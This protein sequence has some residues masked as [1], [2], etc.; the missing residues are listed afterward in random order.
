M[1]F[2]AGRS[3]VWIADPG[4]C[5]FSGQTIEALV[6]AAMHS[7]TGVRMSTQHRTDVSVVSCWWHMGSAGLHAAV[8]YPLNEVCCR[9]MG[10][11]GV[12]CDLPLIP[13]LPNPGQRLLDFWDILVRQTGSPAGNENTVI[14]PRVL[15]P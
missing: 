8:A 7:D 10:L 11:A 4:C 5:G 14:R 2:F 12:V 15:M 9:G 6:T 3:V 1:S 13:V